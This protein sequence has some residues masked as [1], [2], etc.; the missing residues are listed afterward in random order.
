MI[1]SRL[2][3][4][5]KTF[6]QVFI[7]PPKKWKRLKK[8]DVLIYDASG[9]ELLLPYLTKYV[10]GIIQLRGESLNVQCLLL[11]MLKLRFWTAKPLQVYA[12]T[13]IELASPKAVITFI[14]NN[15]NFYTLSQSFPNVKTL[16]IQNGMRGGGRDIFATLTQAD[17][18]HVD[19]M[20][21]FNNEFGEMYNKYIKGLYIPIGSFKNNNTKITFQPTKDVVFISQ[22]RSEP[23]DSLSFTVDAS[24]DPVSWEKFY[25]AEIFVLAFLKKWCTENRKYLRIAGCMSESQDIERQFF[26]DNLEDCQWEYVPKSDLYGS[27]TL[28]DNAELVVFIDSA[29]GFESIGRGKKTVGLSC[30]AKLINDPTL[31]FG[32]PVSLAHEGPFWTNSAD[33]SQFERV[34]DYVNLTNIAEWKKTLD[35][36]A[37]KLMRFDSENKIFV[38]L[39]K[40][41]LS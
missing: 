30:R 28:V 1:G 32:W 33:Y 38:D 15:A 25:S 13:F 11:A 5:L 8:C 39:L 40:E 35:S 41:V 27:Y 36:Y 29:L 6:Y 22:Y 20:L 7:E 37:D 18:Y 16:F 26:R 23:A 9:A 2:A 10:V 31:S 3:W 34:M 17:A 24:G 4:R 21:V 12:E 19:Y 14:D